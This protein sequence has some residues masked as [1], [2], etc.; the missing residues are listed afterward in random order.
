[1]KIPWPARLLNYFL[2]C[3]SSFSGCTFLL[4]IIWQ[5]IVGFEQLTTASWCTI[6][7]VS[8]ATSLAAVGNSFLL[9]AISRLFF[10]KFYKYKRLLKFPIHFIMVIVS[11]TIII[12]VVPI[13]PLFHNGY[14]YE[15]ES[16]L[17]LGTTK[18]ALTVFYLLP[19][20]YMLPFLAV[21]EIYAYTRVII[22][23][24]SLFQKL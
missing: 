12:L 4:V 18:Y 5:I 7:T 1:M 3:N 9:H 23:S 13:M 19:T 8:L 6:P 17:C 14:Q 16:H 11:W 21:I 22:S 24:L 2:A 10:L 20:G 15:I